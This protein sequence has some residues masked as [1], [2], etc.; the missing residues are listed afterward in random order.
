MILVKAA[1]LVLFA[2]TQAAG[3]ELSP[4][5]LFER[6]ADKK[7][8]SLPEGRIHLVA[9]SPN[10]RHL[11]AVYNHEA[12]IWDLLEDKA[13]GAIDLGSYPN[14]RAIDSIGFS[15]SGTRVFLGGR[16]KAR[17]WNLE[18]GGPPELLD[19]LK[20]S[21]F[22]GFVEAG[23][24]SPDGSRFATSG[25]ASA[26][27]LWDAATSKSIAVLEGGE[28]SR[29]AS[30]NADGSWLLLTPQGK[31]GLWDGR[32]GE[33]IE[34][35]LSEGTE[36]WKALFSPDGSL[37]L[38]VTKG[39]DA[40]LWDARRRQRIET[41]KVEAG[42]PG[43]WEASFSADGSKFFILSDRLLVVR[44]S[45]TRRELARLSTLSR[46]SSASFSPD[47]AGIAV[48][49]SGRAWI[50]RLEFTPAELGEMARALA[51]ELRRPEARMIEKAEERFRL[52]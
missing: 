39:R 46:F 31:A 14:G 23:A 21:G 34:P 17:T 5:A 19:V 13:A 30:F 37:I 25:P 49:E 43:A 16:N 32:T 41:F 24:F 1:A 10:G 50:R 18:K 35:I 11:A 4:R 7:Q 12:L 8:L 36:Y 22:T 2:A 45:K 47:A 15:K 9:Y 3:S 33:R 51:P 48:A 38:A 6:F 40:E 27:V 52:P 42:E 26:G 20:A 29:S 44:D 28:D